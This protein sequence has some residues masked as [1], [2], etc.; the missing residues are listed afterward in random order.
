M[1][2]KYSVTGIIH[3]LPYLLVKSYNKLYYRWFQPAQNCA[4]WIQVEGM[5][6]QQ[7][8]DILSSLLTQ[9]HQQS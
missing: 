1:V 2:N 9:L 5:N 6:A 3:C 4:S 7:W 8:Q